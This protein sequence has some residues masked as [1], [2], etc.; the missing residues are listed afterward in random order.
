[1]CRPR[2]TQSP[3][4]RYQH[5]D[6]LRFNIDAELAGCSGLLHDLEPTSV[7]TMDYDRFPHA[8]QTG[9]LLCRGVLEA[10][11]L[12]TRDKHMPNYTLELA[13]NSA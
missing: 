5:S 9:R 3:K 1:M 2:R 7:H 4:S 8:R 12:T 6:R 13:D 11:T 10:M